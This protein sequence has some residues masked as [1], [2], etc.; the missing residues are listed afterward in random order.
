M[1]SWLWN[2]YVLLALLNV[3]VIAKIAR[4][5]RGFLLSNTFHYIKQALIFHCCLWT[6]IVIFGTFVL[7]IFIRRKVFYP[8]SLSLSLF[9]LKYI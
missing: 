1:N 6:E 8:L 5:C 2:T 4:Q 7:Y 9:D 3:L